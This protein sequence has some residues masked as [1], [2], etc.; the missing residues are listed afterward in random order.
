MDSI[1]A[2][3]PEDNYEDVSGDAAVQ[4]IKATVRKSDTCFFCTAVGTGRSGGTRPMSVQDVD[5]EG[6]LWFLSSSD[7]HKNREI[8]QQPEVRLFLQGAEHAGFLVL[9]GTAS[10]S[11]DRTKIK[12]LWEPILRTWFT[13]GEDDPRITVI[14]VQPTGGY[15]W[16]NKHGAVVAGAKMLV[17][18]AIGKTLDDSIEGRVMP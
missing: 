11:T 15:Y 6:N 3:Q 16:D 14:R 5:D 10:I 2:Q 13:G 12:Q 9:T 1:N 18:A 7:S 17:G 8:G 4:R